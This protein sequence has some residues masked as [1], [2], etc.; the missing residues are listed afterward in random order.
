MTK[1]LIQFPK[2]VVLMKSLQ[3]HIWQCF[4]AGIVALLP[5]AGTLVAFIYFES[6]VSASWLQNQVYYFPGLGILIAVISTYLIGLFFSNFIGIWIW[7]TFDRLIDQMPIL[8]NLYKTLKQILGYG[9]GED[10]LFE[11]VVLVKCQ[12]FPGEELG[13]VTN[14]EINFQDGETLAVFLPFS[15]SPMNGRLIFV[16]KSNTRDS[17]LSVN[18]ALKTLVSV[19]TMIDNVKAGEA[20]SST[21]A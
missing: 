21:Q 17:D 19:G 6:I 5:I 16:E 18:Q 8:G 12:D 4:V 14:D 1:P 9:E 20:S 10:A 13:L 2:P 3:N 15:P 7:N 11:R